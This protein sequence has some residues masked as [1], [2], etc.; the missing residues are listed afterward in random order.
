MVQLAQAIALVFRPSFN[1]L[2]GV[3]MQRNSGQ[4]ALLSQLPSVARVRFHRC[5][6]HNTLPRFWCLRR[7]HRASW[8]LWLSDSRQRLIAT[9]VIHR[10]SC[11]TLN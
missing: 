11:L 8:W 7:M 4:V 2:S 9:A 6:L 10:L 5:L 3:S 1:S